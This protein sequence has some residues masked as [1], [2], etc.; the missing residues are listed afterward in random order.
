MLTPDATRLEVWGDP[1]A[2]SRSPQLHAAAYRALGLNW[3]YER[4]RVTAAAFTGE[5]AGLS[6][7]WRG[8]SLTMPLKGQAFHASAQRDRRA[9]LT[10]AV[11]TLLLT[12]DVPRGFNTDVG[13]IVRALGDDG[14]H[15]VDRGRIVGAGATAM[16]A[17]V[18]LS[19][20]GADRVEVVARRPAAVAPLARLG[21]TLGLEVIGVSFDAPVHTDATVTI[22]TLPGDAEVPLAAADALARSGGL[23]FDVV[24]G[25]WPTVL[26]SAWERAGRPATSGLGM[27][28]HQALLQVRVFVTGGTED[29]L[30]GESLV[31]AE[32]HSAVVGD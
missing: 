4:R 5:L 31:L 15:E 16:S 14:V 8:L 12:D 30:E 6:D 32:M 28:L 20:L 23:L 25:H 11:N 10:G 22:A 19:E 9:E 3:T 21:T 2:H 24:Y 26:A 18:A 29:A 13:G 1:V 27:L 17:L 7:R